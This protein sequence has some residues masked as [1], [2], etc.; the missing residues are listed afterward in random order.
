MR[1][2]LTAMLY[3]LKTRHFT[4]KNIQ[5]FFL[6]ALLGASACSRV[7]DQQLDFA[8]TPPEAIIQLVKSR[9]PDAMQINFSPVV[10]GKVW[11]G[12]TYG[13]SKIHHLAV[14]RKTLLLHLSSYGSVPPGDIENLIRSLD[15]PFGVFGETRQVQDPGNPGYREFQTV[16]VVKGERFLLT[17]KQDPRKAGYVDINVHPRAYSQFISTDFDDLPSDILKLPV[18]RDSFQSVTVTE[19]GNGA[20]FQ[21]QFKDGI[22]EV[23]DKLVVLYSDLSNNTTDIARNDLPAQITE[24]IAGNPP[25]AALSGFS[26]RRFRFGDQEGYRLIFQNDTQKMHLFFDISGKLRYQ[27]FT[28]SAPV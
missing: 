5:F 28:A 23:S 18:S 19:E 14:S 26:C 1:Q 7:E 11:L 10:P 4:I 15:F 20:V 13:A 6:A 3:F 27:Y 17:S 16:Y 24:W 22:L 9:V 21:L 2:T 25:P 12:V 8:K